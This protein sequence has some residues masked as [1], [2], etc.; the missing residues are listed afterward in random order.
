[1]VHVL[2]IKINHSKSGSMKYSKKLSQFYL[3]VVNMVMINLLS[4]GKSSCLTH[5]VKKKGGDHV[6]F[7]NYALLVSIHGYVLI[8]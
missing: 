1:M 8:H 4:V 2:K 3:K 5:E 6:Q 7:M